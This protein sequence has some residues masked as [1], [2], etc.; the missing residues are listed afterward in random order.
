MI[1]KALLFLL[2]LMPLGAIAQQAVGSWYFYPLYKGVPSRVIDTPDL[3]YYLSLGRLYSYDKR[4]D[5]SREYVELLS[6]T[7]I[8]KIDYNAE[9]KFLFIGYENG[10]VDLLYDDGHVVNLPDIREAQVSFDKGINEVDFYG[11]QVYVATKFGLVV[12]D[13]GQRT[14][15]QSGIYGKNVAAVAAQG[16]YIIINT[17]NRNYSIKR[18]GLISRFDNF[19]Q[20]DDIANVAEM[21]GMGDYILIRTNNLVR[22]ARYDFPDGKMNVLGTQTQAA[23]SPLMR[24]A[25]GKMRIVSGGR[26]YA[27]GKDGERTQESDIPSVISGNA[28]GMWRGCD[29]VWAASGDGVGCYDITGASVTVKTDRILPA[30]AVSMSQVAFIKPAHDGSRI[31]LSTVNESYVGQAKSPRND[32]ANICAIT[33]D[34]IVDVSPV[35]GITSEAGGSLSKI[36]LQS[37]FAVSPLDPEMLLISTQTQGLYLVKNGRQ[38][39]QFTSKNSSMEPLQNATRCYGADVDPDGNLWVTTLMGVNGNRA[40]NI[41]PASKFKGNLQ[42]VSATDWVAPVVDGYRAHS[43]V[44]IV[45]IPNTNIAYLTMALYGPIVV[46]DTNGTITNLAD[47]RHRLIN[48]V[49]DQDGKTFDSGIETCITLDN[50]GA[51]WV[52]TASGLYSIDNPADGLNPDMRVTRLKVPR[53]DGTNFADYLLDGEYITAIAVDGSNNKWIGTQAS[54]LYYVNADGSE[55]LAHFTSDNSPLP[56]NVISAL[57]CDSNSNEI[58]V[59][60]NYGLLR[61]SGF[62]SPGREDYSDVYAYPNPVKPGY[63]GW[64][65]VTG[66]MDNSL[67]KIADVSGSV[68]YQGRSD[69]GMFTWDGCNSAG[70][71]VK[72]GVYYVFA[73]QSTDGGQSSAAVTKILIMN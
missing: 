36:T 9:R 56:D 26:V 54:G 1:K 13:A 69:G 71:R 23:A 45:F 44:N 68:V 6:D 62:H 73:S 59:G 25:D 63:S 60:T 33:P 4:N 64:I 65:T 55:V 40:I 37:N 46:Y 14:V 41:L 19:M 58:Y 61:Y 22:A 47:D 5:E 70:A 67:V 27:Y 30:D 8:S 35:E 16:D 38:V 49:I 29:G 53:N 52:G 66:L 7:G 48:S 10:N 18:T 42:N 21:K 11:N 57:Y 2:T 34:G 15:R 31:Y 32:G 28:Y 39:H 43:D 20:L 51:L 72:S 24:C 17:E 12:F 3:T 50:R